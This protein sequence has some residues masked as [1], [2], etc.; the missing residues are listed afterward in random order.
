MNTVGGNQKPFT[1]RSHGGDQRSA[2]SASPA[3]DSSRIL[4]SWAGEL[5]APTS[6]FLSSGSPSRRV[7]SRLRSEASTWS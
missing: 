6:V 3:C 7:V 4:A 2:P 5:I 1:G